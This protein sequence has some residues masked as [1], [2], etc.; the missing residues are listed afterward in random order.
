MRFALSITME[1][2]DPSQDMKQVISQALEMVKLADQGGFDIVFTAEHHTI[3]FTISPNPLTLLTY[4]AAHT[5]RIRLGSATVVAPYWT[6]LRLA[7]EAAL[8]DLLTDGRLELGIARGAY[9]YEFD[10]MANGIPQQQ[11]VAHV[12]EIIPAIRKLWAGDYAHDGGIW[13][14]PKATS[15]PKPQQQPGPPIW[16]AARDP[17][18]F[19]WAMANGCDIMATPLSRP[20]EEVVILGE[21]FCKAL[22]DNPGVPRPR[23]LMLRRAC[24]YDRPEDWQLPVDTSIRYGRLFENLFKNIGEVT[25]GFPQAVDYSNVTN[26]A[27]YQPEAVRENMLFGTPDEVIEKLD[28]YQ[29]A[30]VDLFCYGASFGLPHKTAM[31]SLELFIDKV[32]PHFTEGAK[33]HDQPATVQ[34]GL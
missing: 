24:V 33:K 27:E 6:P 22:A 25:N 1:R 30:G 34:A 14:F 26:R 15:V 19:D 21:R 16:V 31:H 2:F 23:F 18:T 9:Q 32:M 11:G 4:W 17:G 10:R 13:S 7:G 29:K 28:L 5:K 8:C 20:P 3:E 12:K